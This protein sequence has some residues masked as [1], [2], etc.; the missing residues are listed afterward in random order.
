MGVSYLRVSEGC[1]GGGGSVTCGSVRGVC[2]G[3]LFAGQ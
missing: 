1:V 2:G 3:Q